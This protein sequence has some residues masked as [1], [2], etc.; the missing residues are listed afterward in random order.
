MTTEIEQTPA[1]PRSFSIQTLGCKVNQAD[2]E[3]IAAELIARGL[4]P[5]PAPEAAD[6]VVVNTCTVTHLGDRS[7]RQAISQARRAAPHAT[8]VA[9]GCY[10]QVAP[11]AVAALPGVDVV[12]PNTAKAALADAILPT[13]PTRPG[14]PL[15]MFPAAENADDR[16]LAA[17]LG[18]TR[19]QVKVQDG[20]DNRCTYCIVPTAR[21][22]S[23]SRALADVVSFVQRKAAAGIQE[24]VLTGIHLGDYHP[25]PETDLGDLLAALLAE[26]DIPRIRVSSLEPEDFRLAWLAHW[27]NPR[28]CRHL[29]LPLQSGSDALLRRM[30]RR[31]SSDRYRAIAQAAYAAIPGLALTTDIIAGFPG[32]TED[33]AAR[34]LALAEE[35]GFAKMHVFR[36]SPRAGTAAA[37]MRPQVAEPTKRERAEALL[38]L[39]DRMA[40]AFRAQHLGQCVNVLWE[41][42]KPW[43][44]EGLTDNYLRVELRDVAVPPER[45]LHDTRTWARVT[46]L[47]ADGVQALL[48][49]DV[50]TPQA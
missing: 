49:D 48:C 3:A 47:S 17:I 39:N 22:A 15:P 18:K 11:Q 40:H 50:P 42:R 32:E 36:F 14:I 38:A 12:V 13:L 37:R 1:S 33:D 10:A 7:S 23:R 8:I 21:G 28:M 30:A 45:D 16:L 43:G 41:S 20:C 5:A 19:V 2:S 4:H 24:V 35:L 27:A 6:V 44:W 25:T 29:H 46:A 26:T 9:T 31:Y 34:T